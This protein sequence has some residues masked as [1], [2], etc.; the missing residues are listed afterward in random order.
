MTESGRARLDRYGPEVR[1]AVER[2]AALPIDPSLHASDLSDVP[3]R[4]LVQI[5][6]GGWRAPRPRVRVGRETP[7]HLPERRES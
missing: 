6:F 1:Y 3:P 7:W 5:G 2:Q 4:N